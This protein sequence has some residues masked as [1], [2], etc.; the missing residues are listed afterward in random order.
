MSNFQP[1]SNQILCLMAAIIYAC[2]DKTPAE[3]V[4]AAGD[5]FNRVYLLDDRMADAASVE[6]KPAAPPEKGAS[7]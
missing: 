6:A 1:S 4:T 5:I 3:S 2:G 7:E